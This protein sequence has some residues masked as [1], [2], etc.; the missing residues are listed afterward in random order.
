MYTHSQ[1]KFMKNFKFKITRSQ[2]NVIYE[3]TTNSVHLHNNSFEHKLIVC[4]L[5]EIHKKLLIKWTYPK[6][7]KNTIIFSPA[8]AIAF[9]LYY[10]KINFTDPFVLATM[11]TIL[12]AIHQQYI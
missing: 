6:E 4:E 9:M 1:L 3:L 10:N 8:Q 12:T 7:G 2:L 5:L 11:S